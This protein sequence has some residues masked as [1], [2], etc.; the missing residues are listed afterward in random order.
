MT[1]LSD[2]IIEKAAR[3]IYE[4]GNGPINACRDEARA[5]L[6]AILP[7]IIEECAKVAENEPN[8]DE[9]ESGQSVAARAIRA[10]GK[11]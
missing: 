5:A 7:D 1:I 4:L 11:E 2:A 9:F 10:L 8:Y 6:S 3:A